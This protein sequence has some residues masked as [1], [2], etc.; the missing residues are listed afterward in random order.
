MSRYLNSTHKLH[1]ISHILAA[2]DKSALCA[3]ET[4]ARP[5]PHVSDDWEIGEEPTQQ[6]CYNCYV[7]KKKLDRIPPVRKTRLEKRMEAEREA[8]QKWNAQC[9]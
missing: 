3:T 9:K 5:W 8:F 2:D 6:L 4:C 7:L 1:W